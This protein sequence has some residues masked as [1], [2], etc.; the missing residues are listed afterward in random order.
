MNKRDLIKAVAVFSIIAL[1]SGIVLGLVVQLTRI[2]DEERLKRVINELESFYG[3]NNFEPVDFESDANIQYFFYDEEKDIYAIVA[4]GEKGYSDI[5]VMY[6]IIKDD[7]IAALKAGDNKET[8]GV[9][10]SAFSQNFFARFLD[11]DILS[12][13]FTD[14]ETGASAAYSRRAV[15]S[16]IKNAVEFYIE[17]KGL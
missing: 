15:V 2:S 16:S 4:V 14:I 1:C 17:Y 13:S 8:P 5:V 6:V 3:S 9:S 12:I 7:K 11:K 10:D